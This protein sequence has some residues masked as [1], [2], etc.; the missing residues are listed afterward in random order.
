MSELNFYDTEVNRICLESNK[1][2]ARLHDAVPGQTVSFTW[3]ALN[4]SQ[5]VS[6]SGIITITARNGGYYE[7]TEATVAATYVVGE[8]TFDTLRFVTGT[9]PFL[10]IPQ[11]KV[12]TVD[13]KN[14][15]IYWSSNISDKNTENETVFNVAV[16]HNGNEV[17]SATVSGNAETLASFAEI[18]GEY[19]IFDYMNGNNAYDVTISVE[20]EGNTYS[21]TAEIAVE[22]LPANVLSV[23]LT[24]IILPTRWARFPL[25]GVLS[26]SIVRAKQILTSFSF[27][28]S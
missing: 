23:S 25:S 8:N 4:G 5:G 22:A 2:R 20:Y 27:S 19:L 14:A 17:Y 16:T 18:P 21:D 7:D 10:T 28:T 11:D 13:G 1:F 24:A 15:V 26:I 9:T 3:N 12:K 6:G